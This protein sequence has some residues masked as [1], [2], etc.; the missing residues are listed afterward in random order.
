M[1]AWLLWL[2]QTTQLAVLVLGV[3]FLLWIIWREYH[4]G[5][6]LT[7]WQLARLVV[8]ILLFSSLGVILPVLVWAA[9]RTGDVEIEHGV[10]FQKGSVYEKVGTE[11]VLLSGSKSAKVLRNLTADWEKEW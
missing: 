10:L 5:N 2:F 4:L 6:D 11:R 8:T 7:Y 9:Y 1:F 3:A